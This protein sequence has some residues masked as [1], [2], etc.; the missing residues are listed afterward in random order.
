M[1]SPLSTCLSVCL[2][3][4]Y[5]HIHTIHIPPK[6]VRDVETS[7]TAQ[8]QPLLLSTAEKTT[9]LL[10]TSLWT[11]F[12]YNFPLFLI[13]LLVPPHP[14]SSRLIS[15]FINPL[16]RRPKG[17]NPPLERAQPFPEASNF[18]IDSFP[19]FPPPSQQQHWPNF[20]A[21]HHSRA[22]F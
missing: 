13:S 2:S 12:R 22:S 4:T 17:T 1:E 5:T 19:P 11:S 16:K 7:P 10:H 18:A 20:K 15:C 6:D 14:I 8:F 9:T 21:L 3:Q